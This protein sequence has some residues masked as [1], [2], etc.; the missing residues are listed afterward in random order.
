MRIKFP[1]KNAVKVKFWEIIRIFD[2]KVK[3][4]Q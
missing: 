3:H 4:C 2:F 1:K